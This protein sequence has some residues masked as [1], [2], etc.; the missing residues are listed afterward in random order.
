M[1]SIMYAPLFLWL[2][3]TSLHTIK[4]LFALS[5]S[6]DIELKIVEREK[7]FYMFGSETKTLQNQ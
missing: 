1:L 2:K 5:N 7:T 6:F 4:K 3:Q